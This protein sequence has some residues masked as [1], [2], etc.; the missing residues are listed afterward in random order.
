[1]DLKKYFELKRGIGVLSTAD[2]SGRVDAAIYARPHVVEEAVLAFVMRE[3]L[4]YENLKTNP[5]A[6]YLF[7]EEGTGYTG[8]RLFMTK[9]RETEDPEEIQKFQRRNMDGKTDRRRFLVFFRL[10]KTLP[11]VGAGE[12][13][14]LDE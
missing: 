3:R 10:E 7:K 5:H 11:L 9:I 12:E 8:C 6:V 4:T 1:M 13:T 14:G 2:F